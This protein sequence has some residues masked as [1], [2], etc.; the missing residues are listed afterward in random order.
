M[1]P[2]CNGFLSIVK[3]KDSQIV[4][5]EVDKAID[6]GVA[7][8][9]WRVIQVAFHNDVFLSLN[10]GFATQAAGREV[11]K[12]SLFVFSNGG[13]TSSHVGESST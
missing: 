10:F 5:E 6:D 13:M 9:C 8:S 1:E 11:E 3:I 2:H 4:H 12:E 7:W